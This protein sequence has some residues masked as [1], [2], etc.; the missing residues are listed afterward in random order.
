MSDE[1]INI[2]IADACGW[3]VYLD[4][5][6]GYGIN[7][8]AQHDEEEPLPDFC[9]DLNAMHEAEKWILKMLNEEG[10]YFLFVDHL[11]LICKNNNPFHATARQRAEAF[12][13]TIGKWK[14][15]VK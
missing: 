9:R 14:E 7:H 6:P 10:D 5:N 2:A 12:L 3:S 4:N 1:Q 15:A 8:S 13:K 11:T